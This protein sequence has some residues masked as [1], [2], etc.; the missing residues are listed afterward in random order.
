[1]YSFV[2]QLRSQ[3]VPIDGVGFQSHLD[4]QY[5][6]PDLQTNL[7]RF[8]DLHLQVAMTEAT[9][10]RSSAQNADG[11]YSDTPAR[12]GDAPEAGGL[13]D[14]HAEGLPGRQGVHVLHGLGRLG[15]LLLDPRR[16]HR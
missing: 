3:H 16:V 14:E 8:A 15:Q 13:L 11:T 5:G 9:C 1:M 10:G 7:Q 2:Q 6:Y 4:T 12:P